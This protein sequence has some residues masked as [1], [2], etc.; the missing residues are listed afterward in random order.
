MRSRLMAEIGARP[1][2]PTL[3]VAPAGWGK[4]TLL[5]QYASAFAGPVNWLRIEASDVGSE[6]LAESIQATLSGHAGTD[7]H[8]P[9]SPAGPSRS[10]LV[11][12]D[13]HLIDGSAAERALLQRALDLAGPHCQV[14]IGSRRMPDLNLSR[15]ELSE[16]GIID[17]EQLRFRA[18]EVER[19][20]REIYQEPL[21]AD[22][23]AALSR[24]VGGWAAGLKL[25][26]LSTHGHPL[27]DRRRA[28]AAL[29]GRSALSRAYLTRTVLAE[30]P[31]TLRRFLTRTCVFDVLTG[32]RCDQLLGSTDSQ[33]LLEQLERRQAF[34]VTHN[35]GRTFLYHQVLRAHLVAGL[36]EELGHTAARAWHARAAEIVAEEGAVLEAARCY[37]RAED[38][39]AVHRLLD[40][41]GASVAD[42]GLDPWSDLLPS[43]FIAEDPWLVLAEGRHRINHGQ[44]E[45]GIA[46][47]RRAEDMFPGE[48][49]QARCRGLRA[50]ATA[51]LPEGPPWRGNW[52]GW[53]RAATRRHPAVVAGEA[54][55]LPAPL[56]PL[57][58]TVAH[59]L[60]GNVEEARRTLGQLSTGGGGFVDV[61]GQLLQSAYAIGA[62]DQ[63]AANILADITVE[64]ERAHQPWLGRIARALVALD[65]TETGIKESIAVAEECDRLG[66]RWGAL[67]SATLAGLMA[68]VAGPV[69]P[70]EATRLLSRAR[71]LDSGVVAAWAQSLLAL[72]AARAR[73][74]DAEVEVRRAESTARSAGVPGARVLALAA[75]VY[76]A[77]EQPG[78]LAA[79]YAAAKQAG[80]PAAVVAAWTAGHD[81]VEERAPTVGPTGL[82]V[83]VWCFGGFRLCVDGRSLDWSAIRP[84][85]RAVA[86]ILAMN[87]GRA[88]HRD[89]LVEALWPGVPPAAATRSLHVALSSLRRFFEMNLPDGSSDRLLCRDGDAY[90]L[91]VP[92]DGYSDVAVFRD[93][94]RKVRRARRGRD[95]DYLDALRIAVNTYG[96][97][98]LPEDGPAEW[99]VNE[100]ETLRQQAADA[101]AA[102]AQAELDGATGAEQPTSPAV[103]IARR[104]VEIDPC[105]DEG[106]RLLIEAHRR[107]GNAAAAERARREYAQVLVSLGLDSLAAGELDR[108]PGITSGQRI[109]PPRSPRSAPTAVRG[110]NVRR[111]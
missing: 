101:A 58:Q 26:Y 50:M 25:Y 55:S 67:V 108:D 100:R 23:V 8:D 6:R 80:L 110:S 35:G 61:A 48:P 22:D 88:V 7:P 90:L 65:S 56:A 30:L 36:V 64:A 102:L 34:T 27:A 109:P 76:G 18:W 97:D 43:W 111:P 99:V 68:S 49:E 31:E 82:A 78:Q 33:L 94:L 87:A 38:W 89:K 24:Q 92:T 12:D 44:L 60:A 66:D 79:V 106:W 107:A 62:G 103:A 9:V 16:L 2:S 95:V 28:V 93:A 29:G 41:A 11:I 3:V 96:G 13:L 5:A 85:A 74:P 14:V 10:L 19:L 98:L 21:P 20:L 32:D 53:V 73:L 47:L 52:T 81:A 42:H 46:A 71:S 91:A 75:G 84:R 86:R 1:M 77:P 40:E 17:A 59:L 4:T 70:D 72:A 45:A 105:H 104:C 57:V 15:H 54:E 63:R 37:A 51:W 39:P 69:E 83:S